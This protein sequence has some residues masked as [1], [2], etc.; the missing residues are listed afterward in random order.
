MIELFQ[1]RKIEAT[2]NYYSKL[3]PIKIKLDK[4]IIESDINRLKA[5]LENTTNKF[6]K[7]NIKA[8]LKYLE[9][10][11]KYNDLEIC[12]NV[13]DGIPHSYPIEFIDEEIYNISTYNYIEIEKNHSIIELDL[14]ELN[15]IMAFEIMHEDLGEN[16]ESMEEK[17]SD[18]SILGFEDSKII[19]DII[20]NNNKGS[21]ENIYALSKKLKIGE[22]A[23]YSASDKVVHDYFLNKQ[24]KDKTYRN[25]VE[26]SCKYASAI[27]M[28]NILKKAHKFK[29]D[30]KPI[31]VNSQ[32]I[33]FLTDA[34]NVDEVREKVLDD[35]SIRTFGRQFIVKPNITV[36]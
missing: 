30:V 16:L 22:T 10:L 17:L 11:L 34:Y 2:I 1:H 31:M 19:T 21:K 15:D 35:I 9:K 13:K 4:S 32:K 5:Y 29:E 25:V 26:H 12:W 33:I 7:E 20:I 24:F 6:D 36:I 14:K 23:Y 27:I 3:E 18:C 28:T 8:L